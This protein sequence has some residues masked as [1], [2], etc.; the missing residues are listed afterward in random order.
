M[1][2]TIIRNSRKKGGTTIKNTPT[3]GGGDVYVD[4]IHQDNDAKIAMANVT[5]TP[6]SRSHWHT[7]VVGQ[8]LRVTMGSGWVCD[9]GEKPRQISIGD[10]IYVA[11]E[12]TH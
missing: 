11:P 1:P 9:K 6:C 3:F 7:H 2:S 5:F 8:V 10:L 4:M 12:T